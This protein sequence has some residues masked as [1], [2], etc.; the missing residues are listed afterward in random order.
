MELLKCFNPVVVWGRLVVKTGVKLF[1]KHFD[2]NLLHFLTGV[3]PTFITTVSRGPT[4]R[5]KV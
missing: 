2:C 1:A 3:W 4:K 5:N